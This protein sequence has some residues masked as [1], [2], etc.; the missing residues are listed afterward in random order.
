MKPRIIEL[1]KNIL[2]ENDLLARN[3]RDDFSRN[4]VFVINVVSSP[5]S[6]KTELLTKLMSFL[7]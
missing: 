5:G 6:G 3:L 1:R 2:E 7:I 4:K